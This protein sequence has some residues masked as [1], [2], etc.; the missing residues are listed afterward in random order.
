MN[1]EFLKV[2]GALAIGL[3]GV[4]LLLFGTVAITLLLPRFGVFL[5]WSYS[6]T[7][8]LHDSYYVVVGGRFFLREL[9]LI[10]IPLVACVVI[11][12]SGV[13]MKTFGHHLETVVVRHLPA[14]SD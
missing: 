10:V 4:L 11:I 14:A 7:L 2:T 12:A 13:V 5:P 6:S 8:H 9:S 3:G 1:G